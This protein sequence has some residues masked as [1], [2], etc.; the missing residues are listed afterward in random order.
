MNVPRASLLLVALFLSLPAGAQDEESPV[1]ASLKWDE[2]PPIPNELGVA[3]A[4]AGI[5]DGDRLVVAGGAS[6]PEPVWETE[7]T[8]FAD[9]FSLDLTNP[10]GGWE[11]AS[12]LETPLAYGMSASDANRFYCFGGC[13]AEKVYS[14]VYAVSMDEP[15]NIRF[16]AAG[17]LPGPRAF[18]TASVIGKYVYIFG[19]QSGLGLDTATNTLWRFDMESRAW[20]TREPMPAPGRALHLAAAQSNGEEDCLYIISGRRELEGGEVELLTDVWEYSPKHDRWRERAAVPQC[21]MAGAAAAVGSNHIM[22]FGG[23]DGKLFG[24]ADELKDDH[25]GF[26][27]KAFAYHAI[28][29]TWVEAG[30]IPA[31][32]VTVTPVVHKNQSGQ[33]EILLPSGEIRPRVR[34]PKVLRVTL[35]PPERIFGALNYITLA[36]YL[37]ALVGM[38]FFFS[39]KMHSTEDFFKAGGRI[40]WWAAGVSI[41]GTQ[42]SAITFMAIPA[43][44]YAQGWTRFWGQLGIVMVAPFIVFFFLPFYRRLNVTTAYEYLEKRFDVRARLLASALFILMQFGRIGIVLLLPSLALHVVTGMG[45]LTCIILMGVLCILYTVLGGIE[46][47]IWTDVL[48]VLVLAGGAVLSLI[49][50]VWDSDGWN[51]MV[52]TADLAGKFRSLDFRIDFTDTVFLV[53][54]IGGFGNSLISYGTDQAVIQRYLTTSSEKQAANGIWMGTLMAIPASLLFFM[55]GSALFVFFQSHPAALDPTLD[56]SDYIFPYYIVGYLPAG[57]AGLVIA[58]VFAASMSSLDSSMNSVSAAITTDYYRKWRPDASEDTCLKIARIA[59]V[60]IGVLGT[61]FAIVLA[62]ATGVMSLWDQFNGILGLFGG[63][64]CGLFCLAIFTKRVGALAALVGVVISVGVQ[65]AIKFI[66][67]PELAGWCYGVI[68]IVLCCCIGYTLSYLMPRGDKSLEGL[69]RHTLK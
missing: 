47:V 49:L 32:H 66:L 43:T 6:F 10:D 29:D 26:P 48:Q 4:F 12:G 2:L 63:A 27:K 15:G 33:T 41:F 42:L 37:A 53:A 55:I 65:A 57:I 50:I 36:L 60:A 64:L 44:T 16:T 51:N 67:Y 3:G 35:T 69:T 22:V 17:E 18:G 45:I 46:A 61:I 58:A 40:P 38:G 1:A 68:G 34:S 11:Q 14:T 5:F 19:G 31:N 23:D 30:A 39:R 62:K 21:V 56:K 20:T 52:E 25:P 54:L 8:W 13:D 28:T 9:V 7:K 24:R 59:T